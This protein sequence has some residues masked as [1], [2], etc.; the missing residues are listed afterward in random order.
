MAGGGG[1]GLMGLQ[2]GVERSE[3]PEAGRLGEFGPKT[4][5]LGP[6][7]LIMQFPNRSI[8]AMPL[9]DSHQKAIVEIP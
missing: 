8:N 6:L 5:L 1:G 2:G 3:R 7:R 9:T 4:L